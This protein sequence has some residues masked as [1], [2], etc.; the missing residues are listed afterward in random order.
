MSVHYQTDSFTLIEDYAHHPTEVRAAMSAL[1]QRFPH[2]RLRII[3]QPHRYARLAK[4]IEEFAE[5]LKKADKI[6][7]APVFAAWQESGEVNSAN[8]AEKIGDK[9]SLINGD[10]AVNAKYI[11]DSVIEPELLAVFG[12]GDVEKIIPELMANFRKSSIDEL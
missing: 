12:A 9:A 4:Y 6:L 1:R 2:H 7:I 10:W 8:L 11:A 3:F 5:E